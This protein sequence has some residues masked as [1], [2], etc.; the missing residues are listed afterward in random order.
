LTADGQVVVSLKDLHGT[1]GFWTKFA[2]GPGACIEE[3][4][5]L[6]YLKTYPQPSV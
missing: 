3:I 4:F 5:V 1:F 2:V 6:V